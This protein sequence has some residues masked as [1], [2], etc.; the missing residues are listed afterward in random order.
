MYCQLL[1]NILICNFGIDVNIHVS[2]GEYAWTSIGANL[3][4]VTVVLIRVVVLVF[5]LAWVRLL[6]L[7]TAKLYSLY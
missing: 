6:V 5:A 3:C 1:T 4:I 2:I 7:T